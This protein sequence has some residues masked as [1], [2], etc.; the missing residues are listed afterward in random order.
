[1][2]HCMGTVDSTAQEKFKRFIEEASAS[3]GSEMANCQPFVMLLCENLGIPGPD[4]A[5]E[6]NAFNDY[7]FERRIDF[8]HGDGSTSA[9]RI[10]CYKR[11]SFILEAKQSAKRIKKKPNPN[12]GDLLPEEALQL[13]PGHAKRGTRHWDQIMKA[14]RKQATDYARA[15]PVEHGYPPFLLI[16]D[17]GN[18]IEIYADF[19][20][21]GKNYAHFPDR[22][23]YRIQMDDL[24]KEQVQQR[25]IAIWNDPHSLDPAKIS[26]QVTRDIAERLAKIAKRLEGK[27]D[28]ADVAEFLMRCLFTMFAED[29]ELIPKQAF[30]N[31]LETLK[32]EPKKFVPALENL[33]KT[34]N[35]GGYE[36]QMMDT[37]KRF[38]GSL[39]KQARALP[40]DADGIHE[41]WVAAKRDWRDVEPAIFGTLLERALDPR[42]RSKLG[43]HYTPRAYVERLVIPTIIEPL[44]EDWDVVQAQVKEFLENGDDKQAITAVKKFHHILCTTRVLD[45][46]CGTGNFLYVSLE[47][48]KRLEGEVLEALDALGE[49]APKLAM[50]GETVGPNQFYGLEINPRA[51]P[52]ADLVLWIGFLKW[53]LKTSGLNSITEPVLDAYGTIKHQDAIL[54]FDE[55][56]LLRDEN[57]KPLSRWDGITK[58]IHPITGEEIP[59]PDAT[60]ALY[61]YSNPRK[62]DWPE[63]EFIVGNPP[64]IG[65]KDMRAELGDGYAQACWKARPN[66]PGG[67]D[68]VMHFWDEAANR[69]ARKNTKK[70]PNLLRRFGFITTNSITQT[71]SRRVIEKALAGKPPISLV[72]AIADHPWLKASDKAAVRIAMTVAEQGRHEGVLGTVAK[73][74]ALNTDTPAVE[75]DHR[76]GRILANL[77]IGADVLLAKTL[78]SN[79]VISSPGVKL[80]GSGFIVSPNE[81]A[82]LGLGKVPGLENHILN[83]RNGRDLAQRSRNVMVIDLFPMRPEEVEKKYPAVH[84]RLLTLVKPER[85]H[86]NMKFRR[87][88]WNW[89][90]ATHREL[91]GFLAGLPRYITT[92]ETAKHRFFQ[93]LDASIRPDNKLVNVGTAKS[94][95]LTVL[96]SRQHVFWSLANGGLLED[97]PVYVKT[98]DFDPFPFPACITDDSNPALTTRLSDLGERLDA[99]RKERLGE[100]EFL[101][102]TAMYNVLERLRE[103][104][105][106]C[107]VPPLT[108]TE[109]DIHE[110]ELISVLKDIHDEIDRATFE[111]YGWDDLAEA[112]VGR[113]GATMPSPHKSKQQEEAEEELLT[114]LVA[115]NLERKEEEKRGQ[116]RWLRP[117]YQIPKL[118]H[119][120]PQADLGK[121]LDMDI[122]VIAAADKPKWPKDGLDQIRIVRDVLTKTSALALPV[123]IS[124]NFAGKN[125]ASRKSR[126]EAVLQTL[127]E[128]GAARTGELDGS[129]RYFIPK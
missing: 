35:S 53:Q 88:N 17:V 81:A 73:E 103:L 33:W 29:V 114:R 4:F 64:F 76:E 121:A 65:G 40:L 22:Q 54:D 16:V 127:V 68:F 120:V 99:F 129:T 126:I 101:T 21:Q 77:T 12:Q 117:D 104:D 47:L 9:G 66:I 119:K 60:I 98:T 109:R 124:A 43:A 90:G 1:M 62:A 82:A 100:H 48:L 23:S 2:H 86:N 5:K 36:P 111:A 61:T 6:E 78:F 107:D 70:K 56:E 105:N 24:L 3:G 71:F 128:T 75:L 20:G 57:G 42:E 72:F 10:D 85:D 108:D 69:L 28:P 55:R 18:V 39:F 44:R 49:D 116:V 15:L 27:H 8:K 52:I 51:V 30:E 26:A 58:K 113:P 41:L 74:E 34:M 31:L 92:I 46:A 94:E 79:D 93:F 106:G 19:S 25:L 118:G 115:L 89:F 11:G 38:N 96:S 91:R 59:D 67:A 63:V 83:Y 95:V 84:Q 102:M 123:E 97:R 125:T 13:K 7:V 37:L 110:A 112:L 32:G 45:P 122:N 80:H 50:H 14:A 87:E